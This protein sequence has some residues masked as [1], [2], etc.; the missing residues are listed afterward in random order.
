MTPDDTLAAVIIT[1]FTKVEQT[2]LNLAL[3]ALAVFI[4]MVAALLTT[5]WFERRDRKR[6]AQL[7]AQVQARRG[8]RLASDAD[9]FTGEVWV[10]QEAVD[11][12]LADGI[13]HLVPTLKDRY[14]KDVKFMV[15]GPKRSLLQRFGM[16]LADDVI[17]LVEERALFARYG[18]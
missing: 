15:Y 18:L 9:L 13:G 4:L 6:N 16:A 8:A 5:M 1:A 2:I 10:G 17:G 11:L 12:G 14:G 7:V 3:I